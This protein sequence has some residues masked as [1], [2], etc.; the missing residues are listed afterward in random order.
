MAGLTEEV[1]RL[2]KDLRKSDQE[3]VEFQSTNSVVLLQEQG[4]SAGNYLAALN[5][6]LSFQIAVALAVPSA[7]RVS[8][9]QLVALV[10]LI[11]GAGV[12]IVSGRPLKFVPFQ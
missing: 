11:G 7:R 10:D 1:L 4:N 2:E 9:F 6:R 3:L 12:V 5:Q 8:A